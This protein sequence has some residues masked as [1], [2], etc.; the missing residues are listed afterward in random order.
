MKKF[1]LALGAALICTISLAQPPMG[2][3]GFP[4]GGGG[5]PGGG[6]PGGGFPGGGMP[7]GMMMGMFGMDVSTFS[8]VEVAKAQAE[9]FKSILDLSDKQQKKIYRVELK[10]ADERYMDLLK[11]QSNNRQRGGG[12]PRGTFGPNMNGGFTGGGRPGMPPAGAPGMEVQ[13]EQD[14]DPLSTSE[15]M[16]TDVDKLRKYDGMRVKQFKK[17]L[18]PEQ[19]EKWEHYK[20]VRYERAVKRAE[21]AARAAAAAAAEGQQG[22]APAGYQGGFPGGA[23]GGY[24]GGAPGGAPTGN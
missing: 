8:S 20:E 23:P 22:Q 18:T 19:I 15:D 10:V 16:I 17:I 21:M 2:G 9:A 6:F 5:F 3:G 1:I 13:Q 4:G 7:P 11:E 24:P 12:M 14:D